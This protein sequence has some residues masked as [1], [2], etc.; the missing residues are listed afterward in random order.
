MSVNTN[1]DCI[2]FDIPVQRHKCSPRHVVIKIGLWAMEL[3]IYLGSWMYIWCS[4]HTQ[5]HGDLRM[6]IF[7]RRHICHLSRWT[8]HR[9]SLSSSLVTEKWLFPLAAP[10]S[11]AGSVD[12]DHSVSFVPEMSMS[13][14]RSRMDRRRGILRICGLNMFVRGNIG[15]HKGDPNG[16]SWA[17]KSLVYCFSLSLPLERSQRGKRSF[18]LPFAKSLSA[19]DLRSLTSDLHSGTAMPAN[20]GVA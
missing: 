12:D 2:L 3:L 15:V 18:K 1:P 8:Q 20:W 9:K 11:S 14:F 4:A 5:H 13:G 19:F 10:G 7:S 6:I 17:T 16:P